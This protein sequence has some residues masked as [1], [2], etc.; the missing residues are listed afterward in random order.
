MKIQRK[1]TTLVDNKEE[2]KYRNKNINKWQR[3]TTATI[4]TVAT[5]ITRNTTPQISEEA[6]KIDA[7]YS[8]IKNKHEKK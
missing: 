3:T 6:S 1:Q 8:Q 2:N 4:V 5:T 7:G